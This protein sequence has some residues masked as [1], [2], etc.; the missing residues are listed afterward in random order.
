MFRELSIQLRIP[1]IRTLLLGLTVMRDFFQSILFDCLFFLIG[2]ERCG[3]GTTMTGYGRGW[4]H[5][6]WWESGGRSGAWTGRCFR[7]RGRGGLRVERFHIE[8]ACNTVKPAAHN[9][10]VRG[11]QDTRRRVARSVIWQCKKHVASCKSHQCGRQRSQCGRMTRP[12]SRYRITI[13]QG[14]IW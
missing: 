2:P 14:E 6:G 10:M 1:C 3:A 8:R 4:P 9:A 13:S 7:R 5:R 12:N 11:I